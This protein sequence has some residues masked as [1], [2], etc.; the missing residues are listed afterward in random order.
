MNAVARF[1]TTLSPREV[2]RA[3]QDI[4]ALHR[5]RRRIRYG[6]RTLDVDILMYEDVILDTDT[7][8][9]PHPGLADRI[10]VLGPLAE[11]DPDLM[12]P[13]LNVTM[14]ALLATAQKGE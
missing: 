14:R 4:E 5:R 11:I 13:R 9:L 3:C 1:E 7:L 8:A 2:L 12:H 10:F 6:A